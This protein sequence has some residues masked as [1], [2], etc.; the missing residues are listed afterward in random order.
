MQFYLNKKQSEVL[1]E[2]F[3]LQSFGLT[4]ILYYVP[5]AAGQQTQRISLLR[6]KLF[7]LILIGT[8]S[9]FYNSNI[10]KFIKT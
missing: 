7:S 9:L 4:L 2:L 5:S 10:L 8:S 3:I 1:Q 6:R